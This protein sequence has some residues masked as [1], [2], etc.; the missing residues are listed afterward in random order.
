MWIIHGA[1]NEWRECVSGDKD[2]TEYGEWRIKE[3]DFQSLSLPMSTWQ[4]CFAKLLKI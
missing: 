2:G 1:T 3:T 4:P